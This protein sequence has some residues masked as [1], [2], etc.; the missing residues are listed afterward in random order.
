MIAARLPA[1]PS[2][3][4]VDSIN[5][6][7]SGPIRDA[8]PLSRRAERASASSCRQCHREP[9][10][11]LPHEIP[12]AITDD[13][14]AGPVVVEGRPTPR[15]NCEERTRLSGR[16]ARSRDLCRLHSAV[17]RQIGHG[18]AVA[19]P[20]GPAAP[21]R[22]NA[23]RGTGRQCLHIYLGPAGF[24]GRVGDQATVG[25]KVSLPDLPR[26][27]NRPVFRRAVRRDDA[28]RAIPSHQQES[29]IERPVERR[30]AAALTG[31]R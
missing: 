27:G 6:K 26:P 19:R 3:Q 12:R 8:T 4:D 11:G 20:R 24:I 7:A 14:E 15:R 9:G 29:S 2:L 18:A 10:R 13:R 30:L 16:R 23:D 21:F 31:T 5:S 17:G 1:C 25:G 22:R 28:K